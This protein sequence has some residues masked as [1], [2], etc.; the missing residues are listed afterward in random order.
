MLAALAQRGVKLAI[1][2]NKLER[3]AVKL[4]AEL[5]LT[6]HFYTI[7]GGDT[8][9]PGRAKPKPDLLHLMVE[10]SGL[11]SPRAAYVGDTTFDTYAAQAA[12]I[13]CVAVSFGFRDR[14][15]Q[16]LG[17]D[18]VIDHFGELVGALEKL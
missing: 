12:A 13:P 7:I 6:D 9:G 16:D 11:P 17:A 15:A 5:G 4:F 10:R 1:V 2:T 8:L 3:L 14:P 18:A